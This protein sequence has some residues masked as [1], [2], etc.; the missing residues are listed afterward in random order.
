MNSREFQEKLARRARR[1]GIT[2][3]LPL[4]IRLETYYRL[5]ST[6]NRKINLAGMDLEEATPDTVDRLLI[7][8]LLASKHAP[9]GARRII[10]IGSGGGSPAIP[11][12]LA[13]PHSMLLMVESKVR[14]SAFLKEALR[15]V[16]MKD[17]DVITSRYESLLSKPDL[18]E[19]HELLTI[20]AVRVEPRVLMSLQAFVQPGGRIFLF[21]SAGDTPALMPPLT[22]SATL[23]LIESLRSRLVIVEKRRIVADRS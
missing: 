9:A 16:E 6:W 10:D 18:H 8:P 7:E 2:I 11:F 14:K 5:L 12:A 1:A 3:P 15:A 17:G 23:P 4:A 22:L 19:A 21:R 13:V 20:R